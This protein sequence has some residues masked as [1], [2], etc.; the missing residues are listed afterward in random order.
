MGTGKDTGTAAR[1]VVVLVV[2]LVD[3]TTF[4]PVLEHPPMFP[5]RFR[6]TDSLSAPAVP[7]LCT[8]SLRHFSML[9][10]PNLLPS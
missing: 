6:A 2:V 5:V 4:L 8:S 9:K 10:I 1:L 3:P 7:S